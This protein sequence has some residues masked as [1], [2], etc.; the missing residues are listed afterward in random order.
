MFRVKLNDRLRDTPYTTRNTLTNIPMATV[1]CGILFAR[2]VANR[3]E[4]SKEIAKIRET[5]VKPWQAEL[6]RHYYSY[7]K[8]KALYPAVTKDLQTIFKTG[9]KDLKKDFLEFVIEH[10]IVQYQVHGMDGR[11]GEEYLTQFVQDLKDPSCAERLNS[12]LEY[13]RTPHYGLCI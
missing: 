4:I 2:S 12:A 7:L 6:C 11:L 9:A 13:K 10:I 8:D 3:P 5:G 1:Y